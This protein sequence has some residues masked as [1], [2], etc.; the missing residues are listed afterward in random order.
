MQ[1]VCLDKVDREGGATKAQT[2]FNAWLLTMQMGRIESY[3]V[4]RK[5]WDWQGAEDSRPSDA[6]VCGQCSTQCMLHLVYAVL[7]IYCTRCILHLVYAA[8][9]VCC[10]RWMLHSVCAALG[11]CCSR[12]MLYSV[13]AVLSVCCTRC[14][15]YLVYAVLCVNS[16][17]CHGKIESDDLTSS[18]QVM[19]ELRMI[20]REMEVY[21]GNHYEKLGL[22]RILCESQF[23][24][25]DTPVMYNEPPYHNTDTTFLPPNQASCTPHFSYLL[26]FSTLFSFWFT[27]PHFQVHN[28]T[29]IAAQKMKTFLAIAPCHNHK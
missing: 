16:W 21:G 4:C 23:T 18:S 10:T 1:A 25:S 14:M 28:Y 6:A 29:I 17:S 7:G 19:I 12:C 2:F 13:Y 11:V 27:I 5:I 3:M 24:I 26:I 9:G 22:K 20:N 8:L 15:L